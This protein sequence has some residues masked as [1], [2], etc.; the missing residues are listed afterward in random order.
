MLHVAVHGTC[1]ACFQAK[2]QFCRSL[3]E[4]GELLDLSDVPDNT[5]A[6]ETTRVGV[7]HTHMVLVAVCATPQDL[8]NNTSNLAC[9]T[10]PRLM[11]GSG[12]GCLWGCKTD[13]AFGLQPE[14]MMWRIVPNKKGGSSA[15][16]LV[17]RTTSSV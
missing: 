15:V 2:G 8:V 17:Y 11:I 16:L 3:Q 4:C 14:F 10:H 13:G 9:H 12:C 1:A 7:L 6:I 5:V